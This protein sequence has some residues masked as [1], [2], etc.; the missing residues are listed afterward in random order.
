MSTAETNLQKSLMDWYVNGCT[1][2]CHD[3]L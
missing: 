3:I 1:V 2:H